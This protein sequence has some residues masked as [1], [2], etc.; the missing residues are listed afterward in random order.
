MLKLFKSESRA[1]YYCSVDNCNESTAKYSSLY[2]FPKNKYIRKIWVEICRNKI[3]K[4]ISSNEEL[5]KSLKICEKHFEDHMFK[6]P[7]KK[8]KLKPYAV[9]TIFQNYSKKFLNIYFCNDIKYF[10]YYVILIHCNSN[11]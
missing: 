10:I 7:K 11:L 1:T 2:N 5:I 8:S 3:K 6:S 4:I 9:P